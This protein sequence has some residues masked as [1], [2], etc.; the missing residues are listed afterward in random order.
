MSNLT[1]S[2]D[3][4]TAG[5]GWAIFRGSDL[6][7]SGVLK[8]KSKSYFERGRYMASELRA[9]QSRALQ[10]FDCPFETIIVE[11]NNVMGPNQQSMMSIGIVTGLILG[12]LIADQIVFVNVSTWRKHWKFSYKDRGK[13]SMKFQSV[14]KVAENFKKAVKDDEAD[15]ILI[16][17]Y[18]V[19]VGTKNDQLEKHGVR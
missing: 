1:L 16:G 17:S 6:V 18:F 5:T 15:A 3:I 8:H 9:I 13:K 12:R 7:Q 11:K 4:S 14:A 2:L 10:K 19:D